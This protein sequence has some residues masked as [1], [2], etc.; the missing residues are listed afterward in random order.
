MK[1]FPIQLNF[2][3]IAINQL[4]TERSLHNGLVMKFLVCYEASLKKGQ[5]KVIRKGSKVLN[6]EMLKVKELL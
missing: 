4:E 6:G 2:N 3:Q 5:T 1:L